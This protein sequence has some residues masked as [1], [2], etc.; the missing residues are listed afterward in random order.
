V[1]AE[2]AGVGATGAGVGATGP[3]V[4]AGTDGGGGCA[5]TRSGPGGSGGDWAAGAGVKVTGGGGGPAEAAGGVG[6]AVVHGVTAARAQ[7]SPAA[8]SGSVPSPVPPKVRYGT[9]ETSASG[10]PAT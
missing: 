10:V 9:G 6:G 3:G 2:G 1:G 4:G 7:Q 5:P 8:P